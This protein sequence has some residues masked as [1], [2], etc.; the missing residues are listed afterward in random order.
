MI[1]W[2]LLLCQS[3]NI[4]I[5]N[6]LFSIFLPYWATLSLWVISQLHVLNIILYAK[7]Y[8]ILS[9]AMTSFWASLWDFSV[10]LPSQIATWMFNGLF[11]LK[12]SKTKLL[13]PNP[14]S[15][16]DYHHP[17]KEPRNHLLLLSIPFPSP[18]EMSPNFRYSQ[19]ADI[20]Q[21]IFHSTIS[22]GW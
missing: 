15:G 22:L 6:T 9:A 12:I 20:W 19:K 18:E 5:P 8:Q 11:K 7:D 1:L 17:S 10:P 14:T 13:V 21:T 4:V 3:L 2:Q 16:N